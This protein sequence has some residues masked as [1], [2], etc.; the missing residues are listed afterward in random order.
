MDGE[1][2]THHAARALWLILV[3][4]AAAAVVVDRFHRLP[5]H[6][7]GA[8]AVVFAT[9]V[10]FGLWGRAGNYKWTAAA[11]TAIYGGVAVGLDNALML[12]GAALMTAAL[13]AVFAVVITVPAARFWRTLVE[14]V[15][16]EAVAIA[17]GFAAVAYRVPLNTDVFRYAV[18]FLALIG[19]LV[20]VYRPGAGL[21]GLGRRGYVLVGGLALLMILAVAYSLALTHWGTHYLTNSVD[22]LRA[23][24][25]DH[26]GGSPHLLDVV[27][28]VPS[29]CWGVFTR[30]R[31]RQGWW[32]CAFGVAMTAPAA[33]ALVGG[34]VTRAALLGCLYSVVLGAVIGLLVIRL[35]QMFTGSRGR[36]ARRDERVS[37]HR[38]EATRWAPLR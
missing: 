18:V 20:A 35:D 29:L 22:D 13:T 2:L 23:W 5:A 3:L 34:A 8:T 10:V 26:L 12:R 9:L 33:G 38:P 24:S 21:Q 7:S 27:V 1:K 32:M 36:R 31:R 15:I 11:I 25:H 30:A 6:V 17:G 14:V 19:A 37:A 4:A 16:A 28:G